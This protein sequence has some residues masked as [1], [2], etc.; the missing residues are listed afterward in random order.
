MCAF[1][2]TQMKEALAFWDSRFA[3]QTDQQS[4]FNDIRT[5]LETI[6]NRSE[7]EGVILQMES[8]IAQIPNS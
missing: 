4:V 2:A 7:F 1:F 6:E 5:S 8:T 3:V